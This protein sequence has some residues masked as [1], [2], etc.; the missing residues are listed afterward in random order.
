MGGA[1]QTAFAK[2]G[3]RISRR[4]SQLWREGPTDLQ[5]NLRAGAN[6]PEKGQ[7][8]TSLQA[9]PSPGWIVQSLLYRY[10]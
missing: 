3:R 4:W 6:D 1:A 7:G 8:Q 9:P 2:R 5:T 10:R